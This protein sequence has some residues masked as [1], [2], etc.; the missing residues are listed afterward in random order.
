METALITGNRVSSSGIMRPVAV[1]TPSISMAEVAGIYAR[2]SSYLERYVQLGV[3]SGRVVH[4]SFP[5]TPDENAE[6]EY[7]LLDRIE[8]YLGGTVADDFDDVK[9]GLTVDTEYR[10]VLD[11]VRMIPYGEQ[12]SVEQVAQQ[13]AIAPEETDKQRV[14][15][16]ALAENPVPLIIPDHRVQDGPSA[17]PPAVEQRLRALEGLVG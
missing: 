12:L 8:D 10:A 4:V 11:T 7:P 3:A 15:R 5:E 9:V 6:S 17:A 16:E 13:A 1:A 2:E 14:V